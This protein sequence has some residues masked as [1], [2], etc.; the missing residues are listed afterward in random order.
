METTR[1]VF[2]GVK[3]PVGDP[4]SRFHRGETAPGA[5]KPTLFDP[6][7]CRGS[8]CGYPCPYLNVVLLPLDLPLEGLF[9]DKKRGRIDD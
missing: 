9:P 8:P 4:E 6:K 1:A 7:K 3:V 2:T 5:L